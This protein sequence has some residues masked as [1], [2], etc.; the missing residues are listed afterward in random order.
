MGEDLNGIDAIELNE[1]LLLLSDVDAINGLEINELLRYIDPSDID[2]SSPLQNAIDQL[3]EVAVDQCIELAFDQRN[4]VAVD[5][6]VVNEVDHSLT[7]S[8]DGHDEASPH[9]ELVVDVVGNTY[10]VVVSVPE[11]MLK[12]T[13]DGQVKGQ[14]NGNLNSQVNGTLDG[15]VNGN[16]DE[17][18]NRKLIG[19]VKETLEGQVNGKI[20]GQIKGT[21]DGQ[22]NGKLVG[23]VKGTLDGQVKGTLDSQVKGT[24]DGQVKGT[25]DDQVN[26]TLGGQDKGTLQE[27]DI[28]CNQVTDLYPEPDNTVYFNAQ[29]IDRFLKD[30]G[31]DTLY[32]DDDTG[33]ALFPA[34]NDFDINEFHSHRTTDCRS[35]ELSDN[36]SEDEDSNIELCTLG[37][38]KIIRDQQSLHHLARKDVVLTQFCVIKENDE[39]YIASLHANTLETNGWNPSET[40]ALEAKSNIS[41]HVPKELH[42][43]SGCINKEHHCMAKT[44]SPMAPEYEPMSKKPEL[45]ND[46]LQS[47]NIMHDAQPI[48]QQCKVKQKYDQTSKEES[49]ITEVDLIRGQASNSSSSSHPQRQTS[50]L[51]SSSHPQRQTSTSLSSSYPQRLTPNSFSGSHTQSQT[52]YQSSK[53]HSADKI[54]SRPHKVLS[55][56]TSDNTKSP[57]PTSSSM[58]TPSASHSRCKL[59]PCQHNLTSEDFAQS[60]SASLGISHKSLSR[61]K[62]LPNLQNHDV[63]SALRPV[64][65]KSEIVTAVTANETVSSSSTTEAPK[66]R[67]RPPK[68]VNAE[69]RNP[70]TANSKVITTT[71]EADRS[72]RSAYPQTSNPQRVVHPSDVGQSARSRMGDNRN[73]QNESERRRRQIMADNLAGLKNAVPRL[74]Q[75]A[76]ASMIN[77]LVEA[78]AYILTLQ[79]L[80]AR[81][82]QDRLSLTRKKEALEQFL[83]SIKET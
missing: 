9:N 2:L 34:I 28:I 33:T 4:G 71:A 21:L 41:N 77:I 24:L 31:H 65:V 15:Q 3:S 27:P 67:G 46:A 43:D 10:V 62:S 36:D 18:V 82:E 30:V 12:G 72:S 50:S 61:V 68:S 13:L 60:F 80:H 39:D 66:R 73:R 59:L 74:T 58:A 48:A 55:N 47:V 22:V 37:W 40:S 57:L 1:L 63:D 20:V 11:D 16:L 76:S 17:Q 29:R 38:S 79:D 51:L 26:G 49:T 78:R 53:Y 45:D 69:R 35:L 64:V 5:Q 14:V 42:T 75:Q 54:F 52:S 25:L 83:D 6:P 56:V 44:K 81:Q 7:L 23:Q 70:S 19:Q 8:R 32:F